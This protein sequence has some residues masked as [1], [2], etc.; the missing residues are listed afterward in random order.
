MRVCRQIALPKSR[1]GG[2]RSATLLAQASQWGV[3]HH[4]GADL[5][6]VSSNMN[7]H[8]SRNICTNS[9]GVHK[10]RPAALKRGDLIAMIA[11]RYPKLGLFL[12]KPQSYP[13]ATAW[14][15]PDATFRATTTGILWP[16]L[17]WLL[18]ES[19]RCN[20]RLIGC[21]FATHYCKSHTTLRVCVLCDILL[22]LPADGMGI[23]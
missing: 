16:A 7:H 19:A 15:V 12:S 18:H 6:S 2:T 23:L 20:P 17:H 8:I 5:S 22:M 4:R 1:I 11:K 3:C 9:D 10:A 14:G 21:S 13:L